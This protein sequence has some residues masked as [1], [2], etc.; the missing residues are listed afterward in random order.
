M[1]DGDQAR[2]RCAYGLVFA[3]PGPPILL[4]GEE[5]GMGDRLDLDGRLSVRTPMRWSSAGKR[6]VLERVAGG[7]RAPARRCRAHAV[8]V[9]DQARSRNGDSVLSAPD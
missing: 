9:P 7:S 8:A 2:L 5:I 3:L 4:H 1:P 6:R